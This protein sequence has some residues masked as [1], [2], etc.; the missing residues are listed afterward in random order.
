MN[1]GT[2][3]WAPGSSRSSPD[4]SHVPSPPPH[5]WS[6]PRAL[7]QWVMVLGR[8]LGGA[9]LLR[10]ES[11]PLFSTL[12]SF[13]FPSRSQ[14]GPGVSPQPLNQRAPLDTLW[15]GPPQSQD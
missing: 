15:Q 2:L 4:S 11:C 14:N 9:G 12:T 8:P 10:K 3:T 5:I 7:L 1:K 6:P 13:S